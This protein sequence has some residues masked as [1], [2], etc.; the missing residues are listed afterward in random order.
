MEK[1]KLE[2]INFTTIDS[3]FFGDVDIKRV[4]VSKKIP[5]G[6]K[7]FKHFVDYLYNGNK[8]KKLRKMLPK[9]CTYVKSYHGQNKWMHFFD[10]KWWLIRKI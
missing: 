2:K 10:W 9:T 6:K 4:L 5:F 8:K 7:N 3:H 1:L